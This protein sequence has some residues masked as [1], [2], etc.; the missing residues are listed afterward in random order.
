MTLPRSPEVIEKAVQRH[1]LN[2]HVAK[3]PTPVASDYKRYTSNLS[4]FKKRKARGEYNLP[5]EV[6]LSLEGQLDNGIYGQMNPMWVEWLMGY[7]VGWTALK[8]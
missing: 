4:Y 5:T 7:P 8:G 1:R 3:W 2:G 6:A